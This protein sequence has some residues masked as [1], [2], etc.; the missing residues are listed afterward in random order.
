MT[1]HYNCRVTV[2][3]SEA[4]FPLI[5]S[6]EATLKLYAKVVAQEGQAELES[7]SLVFPFHPAFYIQNPEIILTVNQATVNMRV[8]ATESVLSEIEVLVMTNPFVFYYDRLFSETNQHLPS[9]VPLSCNPS[10]R[11]KG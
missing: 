7:E 4:L 9:V 6:F 8:V 5:A 3:A 11:E 10:C 1:G 2:T